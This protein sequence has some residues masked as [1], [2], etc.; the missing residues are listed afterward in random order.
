MSPRRRSMD[1]LMSAHAKE[2]EGCLVWQGNTRL[3]YAVVQRT[4]GKVSVARFVLERKLGRELAAEE[5]ACHTC[6]N[7]ACVK[8]EHLFVGSKR[9]NNR[10]RHVKQRDARGVRVSTSKL[11]DD[12][13]LEL[14]ASPLSC[15]AAARALGVAKSTVQRARARKTW[16][17]V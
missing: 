6:D 11:T 8:A 17:H 13:V 2:V 12:Q 9:E 15:G 1:E 16:S 5:C 7:P 14:D 4:E 3:G 10:D